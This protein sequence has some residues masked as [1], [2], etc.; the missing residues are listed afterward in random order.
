M[1]SPTPPLAMSRRLGALTM[2]AVAI[3]LAG[4][5]PTPAPT[6]TPTAAFASEE[7]AFAAAEAT[8]RAYTD[9]LNSVDLSNPDTFEPV[10]DLTS[11]DFEAADRQTLSQLHAKD[12]AFTGQMAVVGFDGISAEAPFEEVEAAVCVDVSG[13]DVVDPSGNPVTPTDRPDLNQLRVTFIVSD[14][15]MLVDRADRDADVAC[16][17]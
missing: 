15:R 1:I 12:Y 14:G 3:T 16:A 11:G 4:C 5:A 8:Y 13:S 7:E 6:P 9:A 2:V 17:G 10:F